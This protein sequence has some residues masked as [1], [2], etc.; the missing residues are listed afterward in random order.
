MTTLPFKLAARLREMTQGP[1]PVG[2]EAVSKPQPLSVMH[3]SI[4]ES[5]AVRRDLHLAGTCV[6]KYIGQYFL[7]DSHELQGLRR[8]QPS[9]DRQILHVPTQVQSRRVP[10]AFPDGNAMSASTDGQNRRPVVPKSRLRRAKS[11]TLSSKQAL[12]LSGVEI[13]LLEPLQGRVVN[14]GSQNH[15]AYRA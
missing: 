6:L 13:A 9:E 5:R 11:S 3:T 10:S 2:V 4:K 1:R 12:E 8:T 7:N 14:C 15:H